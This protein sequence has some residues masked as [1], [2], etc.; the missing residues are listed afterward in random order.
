MS[1]TGLVLALGLGGPELARAAP[2]SPAS[3]WERSMEEAEA[4]LRAGQP[5]VAQTRYR[6]AMGEGWLLLGTLERVEGRLAE[7]EAAF[8]AAAEAES[9]RAEEAL[10]LLLV[11]KGQPADG[12][13]VLEARSARDPG[14]VTVL[15]LLAEALQA[16]GQ[17]EPAV[18]R[19]EAARALAPSDLEVA[20]ALADGYLRLKDMNRAA[21]LFSEIVEA[22]PLPQT[23]VLIGGAYRRAGEHAR[24]EAE[25]R[26]AL[27]EDP[28]VRR[29][30]YSLGMTILD[31][32][33]KA[34]VEAAT[35]EFQA[36][37]AL[38]PDDP[39]ANLE[40]G[41]ALVEGQRPAEA[42]AALAVAARSGPPSARTFYYLGRAQVGAGQAAEA[43]VSLKRALELSAE[44]GGNAHALRGIHIQ[45][46]QALRALGQADAAAT[47]FAEAS[48]LS[49]QEAGA[50]RDD[51][52]RYMAG[53]EDSR[54]PA[55]VPVLES[56]PLAALPAA[57]RQ[58]LGRRVRTALT[59]AYLNLGVIEA[60]AQRFGEAAALFEKASGLDPDFPQVQSSLGI[61]YFNAREFARAT[62]PLTRAT[63]ATADRGLTRMLAL[64]WLNTESYAK[65]A[66]LLQ[67][68]PEREADASLDFAYGLALVKSDRAAEAERVFSRLLRAHGDSA[69]LSVFLGQAHAQQGD[70]PAAIE[71]LDRA[72]KLKPDVAEASATL[73]IIYL[74]QGRL[75]EA[76]TALRAELAAHPADLTARQNLAVVLDLQ[77]R[78]EEAAPLLRGV[79]QARPDSSDARY[80]LGKVLL[81]QGAAAEAIE[82]LKTAAALAPSDANI[83][84]Q[85]GKAYQKVGKADLAEQEF[86]RFRELK[87]AQ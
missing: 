25:L 56:T 78:G 9:P 7:A 69:E 32:K 1:L 26:T 61:A 19:L 75:P 38:A 71:S 58:E 51:L 81:S 50:Q 33:G 10:A 24:A 43:A 57:E 41:V 64:A 67:D 3:A 73:G 46:G 40:L 87:A 2:P 47:H 44:Q 66:A 21:R 17:S 48:R 39:L 83:H 31:Q 85:L 20:F 60:Q 36:E 72:R 35:A 5:D 86:A 14:N 54:S 62:G 27:K 53:A 74:R 68:D 22:R 34:G 15:R 79:V 76:E 30:H 13:K 77:Q 45:L 29:A 12:V 59:R 8:R 80:L 23:R 16:A 55:A 4:S 6:A 28:R 52:A 84:Y 11:Q 42:V 37:I 63:A 18:R 49:S 70:F 82:Q 65:A